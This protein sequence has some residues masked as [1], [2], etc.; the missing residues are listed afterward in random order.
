MKNYLWFWLFAS[1]A[2]ACSDSN[3][4]NHVG[5]MQRNNLSSYLESKSNNSMSPLDDVQVS[6]NSSPHSFNNV[7]DNCPNWTSSEEYLIEIDKSITYATTSGKWEKFDSFMACDLRTY[8]FT[9]HDSILVKLARHDH[10]EKI[11]DLV[12]SRSINQIPPILVRYAM[13]PNTGGM[14]NLESKNFVINRMQELGVDID[15][16][17][18]IFVSI[19]PSSPL[20]GLVELNDFRESNGQP[21]LLS[22]SVSSPNATD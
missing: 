15:S 5:S 13:A 17:I 6:D 14:R 3:F 19:R 1:L 2:S 18:T 9:D 4:A 16:E 12:D 20:M 10:W 7:N 11:W 21:P 22:R 8:E